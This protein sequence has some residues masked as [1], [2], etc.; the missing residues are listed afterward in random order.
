MLFISEM[1][2]DGGANSEFKFPLQGGT[3]GLFSKFTPYIEDHLSLEHEM[4]EVDT[5]NKVVRFSSGKETSYDILINTSPLDQ[6]ILSMTPRNRSLIEAAKSLRHSGVLSAGI[7]IRKPCP[8]DKCW[9][10]FPEDNCCFYRVTYFSN[11]SP[12]NVPNAQYYYSL[13]CETSYSEC[14]CEDKDTIM[15]KTIDGLINVKLID[16]ADTSLI[17][18]THVI[19]ADYA[20][21]I[22]TLD[23]DK[24]LHTIQ[25]YLEKRGI[26]SRG[27]FGAWK[28]EM[29][30]MD[31]SIM[32]GVEAINDTLG[33]S[34]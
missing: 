15:E 28:Y 30:S 1:N 34:D 9:M 26:Y 20:Y 32:Q 25:P 21:P 4:V 2:V 7:G 17:D 33:K 18:A 3:G 23:R 14:K 24:A 5:S 6:F 16:K 22:P 31:Q 13:M 27:R 10:Y 29:S 19:Q 11:Y 8:S 12:R